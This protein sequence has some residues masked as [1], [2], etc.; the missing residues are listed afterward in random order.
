MADMAPSTGSRSRLAVGTMTGT[1][2]DGLDVALVA[3]G[4]EGLSM[5]A[6]LVAHR[7]FPL[8]LAA[9]LRDACEGK[10]APAG[11]L[12]GLAREFGLAHVEAIRTT[13]GDRRPDL[14]AVHGQTVFHRPPVSWQ[15]VNP[16]P[17]ADAFGCPV[18]SDLRGADLAAGG[19][20]APITPLAD[21]V[22]FRGPG[23]RAVVNLGGFCN[24][25]VLPPAGD[26]KGLAA[27]A[28][29]DACACNQVLDAAAR[30][31]LGRPFD[32]DGA[33]AAGGSADA[34]AT[35]R[36]RA[37]LDRQRSEG[38]SLGTGDEAAAWV[39][40]HAPRLAAADLLASAVAAVGGSIGAAIAASLAKAGHPSEGEILLA[41]G[42]ARNR[43][44]AMAIA[45][46]AGLPC[47]TTGDL[48]VPIEARE[49][50]EMAIL[51]MLAHDGVPTTLPQV[52]GRRETAT[53]DALWCL[54][55]GSI[56]R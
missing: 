18:A 41:G 23:P 34:G 52:T 38:R 16:F 14:V 5:R 20:G 11:E 40:E 24:L 28:G 12:A 33:V 21:W 48:G 37:T 8:G 7:S 53:A 46:T 32:A 2:L 42:G 30:A 25:T 15:L 31:A 51:G 35:A 9:R 56:V 6:T 47:R 3:I 27:I 10:P 26:A 44:L 13:V 43:T 17:I 50:M 29:F 49:A 54:P 45:T 22:L 4:G 19:Q 39:T 1:S 55:R 36:L